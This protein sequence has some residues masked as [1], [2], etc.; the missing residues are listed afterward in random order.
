MTKYLS[1]RLYNVLGYLLRG[2]VIFFQ[3]FTYIIAVIELLFKAEAKCLYIAVAV[4]FSPKPPSRT[5][6]SSVITV[7][8][9]ALRLSSISLSM[10]VI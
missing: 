2:K 9:S 1:K 6:S 7:L 10:P 5:P 8:W 3:H 4:I